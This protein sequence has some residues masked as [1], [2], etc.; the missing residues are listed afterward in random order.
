MPSSPPA[1][2]LLASVRRAL[3]NLARKGLITRLNTG[4]WMLWEVRR[5][6]QEAQT[7]ED[8]RR[9]RAAAEA[10]QRAEAEQ[11]EKVEA[12]LRAAREE[13]RKAE[14]D[15]RRARAERNKAKEERIRAD[16]DALLGRR[17]RTANEN[18][19]RLAKVLGMLGSSHDG[20]VVNAARQAEEIRR[21]LGRT[22]EELL[23]E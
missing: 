1:P 2:A 3:A 13:R 21:R 8:A 11:R 15:R 17:R 9:A 20:E 16:F 22:W 23:T 10:R 12:E 14:E 6:E 18:T 19:R 7:R 4:E 5:R